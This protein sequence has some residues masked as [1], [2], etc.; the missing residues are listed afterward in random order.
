[1]RCGGAALARQWFE[2]IC[3]LYAEVFSVPPFAWDDQESARH[4]HELLDLMQEPSF[5]IATAVDRSDLLGFG[6]GH[7]LPSDTRWWTGFTAPLT[8]DITNEY[9]GRTFALIDLAVRGTARGHGLGRQLIDTLLAKRHEERATLCVEPAA[10]GTQEFYRHA[11][12]RRVG[13]RRMGSGSMFE[14][15]DVYAR[16]AGP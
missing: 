14:E 11:G 7:T 12:W 2:D 4:R 9:E 15:L 8:D 6:Y 5:G 13:R 16:P 1:M 10:T 3:V